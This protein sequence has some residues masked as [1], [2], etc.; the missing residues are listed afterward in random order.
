MHTLAEYSN[1]RTT[2]I[3]AQ[4]PQR[5]AREPER[6]PA[7]AQRTHSATEARRDHDRRSRSFAGAVAREFALLLSKAT[8]S[9][10]STGQASSHFPRRGQGIPPMSESRDRVPDVK[11]AIQV[12]VPGLLAPRTAGEFPE[13]G[14]ESILAAC[15]VL[16]VGSSS[17][18]TSRG[19]GLSCRARHTRTLDS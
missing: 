15:P 2:A 10:T 9:T 16:V 17:R 3:A 11:T 1:R 6:I 4:T 19:S 14:A 13:T 12:P 18:R 7:T 8:R 5:R